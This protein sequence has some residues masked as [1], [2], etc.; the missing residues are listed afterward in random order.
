[1]LATRRFDQQLVHGM[2]VRRLPGDGPPLVWIHGLGE[3]S[4]CFDAIVAHPVLAARDHTLLDLPGYGRSPW[5]APASIDA[6]VDALIAYLGVPPILIGHS[7]GGV[8]ATL[9]AERAPAAVRAVIDVE[10][11]SS[12]GDCTF[13]GQ[14]AA[15]SEDDFVDHG[16]D[17]LWAALARDHA[18]PALRGYAASIAFCDPRQM[19]RHAVDLVALSRAETLAARRA[20]LAVPFTFLAGFPRGICPHSRALLTAAA[21]PIVDVAPAAHWP[22]LDQPDAFAAAVARAVQIGDARH[23]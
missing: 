10:G 15:Y 6:T 23:R 8:V 22:F 13:S 14:V 2:A 7:L 1:M 20:A 9:V 12:L 17:A 18:D 5:S 21:I 3:S 16:H 11:N 19:W 4:R